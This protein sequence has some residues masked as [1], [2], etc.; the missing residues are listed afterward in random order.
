MNLI[1]NL[2][3]AFAAGMLTILSPCVLPLAPVVVASARAED[4][5]GPIALGLGLAATFGVVGGVLASFGVEFGDWDWARAASAVIMIAIGAALLFAAA[6]RRD[7]AAAWFGRPGGGRP[8]RAAAEGGARQAGGGRRRARF[9]L[10]ALRRPD[11]WRG[12]VARRQ[13]RFGS[14]GD[15]D[16]VSLCARRCGRA[17][18]RRLCARPGDGE[19]P[20][21]LGRRGRQVCAWRGV[22][23]HWRVVLTG[24]D[25]QIEAVL[26]AAM[27]DWLTTFATSL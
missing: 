11:P 8:E 20:L 6:R 27:P 26:V 9:R 10:G 7:R 3:L 5:R 15:G 24:L 16:D 22:C 2:P 12:F 13:R 25:H 18:R 21:R 4:P 23:P 14:G 17:H 19:G 1:L